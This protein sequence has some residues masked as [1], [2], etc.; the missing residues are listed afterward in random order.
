MDGSGTGYGPALNVG[1]GD[2][3]K[4]GEGGFQPN[5]PQKDVVMDP[6]ELFRLRYLREAEEKFLAGLKNMT[7]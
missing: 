2:A 5:T 3:D 1:S 6:I 4:L 7:C